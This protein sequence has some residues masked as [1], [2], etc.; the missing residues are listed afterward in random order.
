[1]AEVEPHDATLVAEDRGDIPAPG[2]RFA[3]RYVIESVL[4]RG[5][6]GAVYAAQDEDVGE[7]VALKILTCGDEP[8]V[9]ERFR[10]EVRLA[11]RVTHRNAA[12]TYDL[13]E[14]AGLYYL[15]MELVEGESLR[16]R[17]ARGPIPTAEL[18]DIGVQLCRGLAAAHAVGVVHRDLKPANV[19]IER[20]G[21][22]VVTDFGVARA[23]HGDAEVTTDRMAVVGTPAYMA[24]EQLTGEAIGPHTD[25]FALGVMLYELF[26]GQRPYRGET[27][28]A[29]AT[30]RLT[31]VPVDPRTIA[32]IDESV[33]K[34]LESCLERDV[35]LRPS[36]VDVVAQALSQG[37]TIAED[38]GTQETLAVPGALPEPTS[39]P[40]PGD[41]SLAVL[42]FRYRGPDDEAYLA[43]ALWEELVDVLSMTRG[44]KVSCTGATAQLEGIRDPKQVG[45]RLGVD[46]LVDGTIH[47]AAGRV[48][49][50]ARLVDVGGFQLWTDRFDGTL[51]SVFDLQDRIARR[52]AE[53]LRLELQQRAETERAPEDVTQLYLQARAL[54]RRVDQIGG[55]LEEAWGLLRQALDKAPTFAPALAQAAS[56]AV[57]RWFIPVPD[58][59]VDWGAQSKRAIDAALIGAPHMVE[60][61]TAAARYAVSRG[62]ISGAVKHLQHA[63]DIAPTS[64]DAIAYLG[65]LQCE[66][67]RSED[68]VRNILL[69]YEL[70]PNIATHLVAVARQYALEQR[71]DDYEAMLVR[72]RSSAELPRFTV[73][74][75]E[76]RVA[77]W[78]GDL[79]RV[80][81]VRPSL[82]GRVSDTAESM[83]ELIRDI[84]LGV[85]EADAAMAEI[86]R[87]LNAGAS[88]RFACIT[89]QL[90]AEV[91]AARGYRE[92]AFDQIDKAIASGVLIDADWI[93][94]CPALDALRTEPRFHEARVTVRS[95]ANAIWQS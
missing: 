14:R 8:E 46:A 86:D 94:R 55:R 43:E 40:Q 70:D 72:L 71:W 21:R 62:E 45:E 89:H 65:F 22:V 52:V 44:L 9:V 95:A 27:A 78:R 76:M 16:E 37:G 41:R 24:P 12:R 69:G 4:G 57:L 2:H 6:M 34:V 1:V 11:R 20:T 10:R 75:T 15:T 74:L 50:T 7:R 85:R 92:R 35:A 83:P 60:T 79:E 3:D 25:I 59:E 19:L 18:V 63:L 5:A 31:Q 39:P 49:I 36:S 82:I 53:A 30:A 77:V 23:V 17:M 29:M 26:T 33:A 67:G 68:G 48:R 87:R 93:E 28:M 47:R 73:D 66:A 80:R 42:P 54:T 61:H 84:A 13:G 90:A 56:V 64:A 58:Q 32:T 88:P 91:F 51:E 81:R 38:V